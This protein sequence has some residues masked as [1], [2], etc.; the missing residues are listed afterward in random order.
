MPSPTDTMPAALHS[1]RYDL[2]VFGATG[3]WHRL[4]RSAPYQSLAGTNAPQPAT[5]YTGQFTAEQIAKSLPTNL[6]WAVAGRSR[7]KLEQ[8]VAGLARQY[9]VRSPAGVCCCLD[10]SRVSPGAGDI[11]RH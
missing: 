1:S 5:G 9:P 11:A 2:V 7:D 6:K 4:L 3:S 10:R 8:L